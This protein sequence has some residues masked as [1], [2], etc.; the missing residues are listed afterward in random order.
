MTNNNMA[1]LSY[2]EKENSYFK[3]LSYPDY[4]RQEIK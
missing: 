4:K 2:I 1:I 3:F